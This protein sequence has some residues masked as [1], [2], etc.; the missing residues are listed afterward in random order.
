MG[1]ITFVWSENENLA[2][3]IDIL[4]VRSSSIFKNKNKKIKSVSFIKKC[5]FYMKVR[6]RYILM[7]KTLVGVPTDARFVSKQGL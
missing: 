7:L 1:R 2:S 6:E 3:A 5:Q 4:A